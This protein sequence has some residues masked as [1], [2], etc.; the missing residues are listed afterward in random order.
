MALVRHLFGGK[1]NLFLDLL[2]S[3]VVDINP[4]LAPFDF[5]NQF[6]VFNSLQDIAFVHIFFPFSFAL[7]NERHDFVDQ[8]TIRSAMEY[9]A[10]KKED[11]KQYNKK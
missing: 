5:R 3:L 4:N 1:K 2:A 6:N 8:Q 7:T 9:I 11:K 10:K